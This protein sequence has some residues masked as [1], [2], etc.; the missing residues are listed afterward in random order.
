[1]AA[2]PLLTLYRIHYKVL[3]EKAPYQ[4]NV[5]FGSEKMSTLLNGVETYNIYQLVIK[6]YKMVQGKNTII[7]MSR[8][9]EYNEINY[10]V[11]ETYKYDEKYYNVVVAINGAN[12]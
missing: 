7:Y 5:G 3:V 11:T 10:T 6:L 2:N 4:T 8:T 1:V 12:N 9:V